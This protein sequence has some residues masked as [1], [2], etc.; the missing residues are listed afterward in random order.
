M[1][2][3]ANNT[4]DITRLQRQ[5]AASQ[6]VVEELSSK[7]VCIHLA[8]YWRHRL[9]L[10]SNDNNIGRGLAHIISTFDTIQMLVDEADR[11][12]TFELDELDEIR[13]EEVVSEEIAREYVVMPSSS[14]CS[15]TVFLDVDASLLATVSCLILSRRSESCLRIR[16]L[17]E[18]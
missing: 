16:I 5:L 8:C 9:N 7:K 2:S 10:S 17:R 15:L 6:A 12:L 3:P 13:S 14:H 4:A 1:S 18:T 11:R